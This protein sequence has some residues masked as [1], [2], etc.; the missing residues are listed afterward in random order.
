MLSFLTFSFPSEA[1]YGQLSCQELLPNEQKGCRKNSRGT[2]EQLQ[3]GKA[4]LQNCRMRLTK[5]SMAWID[6]RKAYDIA[7]HS[8]IFECTRMVALAKIIITLKENSME[9][10]KTVLTSNQKV[11]GI[12]DIKRGIVQGDS[13]SLLLFVINTVT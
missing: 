12:V 7:P 11:L 10:W 3:I 8:W 6:Y 9:N 4:I 2:N 13:L 1:I 5:L